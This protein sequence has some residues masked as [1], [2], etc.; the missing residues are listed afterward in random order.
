MRTEEIK[1]R[2]IDAHITQD[3][4][5]TDY[6]IPYDR[7][8][9]QYARFPHEAVYV[10]DCEKAEM[11]VLTD[12]FE[13]L[14]GVPHENLSI[15]P[16]YAHIN[17]HEK[18]KI[19]QG[20]YD[21]IRVVFSQNR[22]IP[23]HDT[24]TCVYKS[25][26]DRILLKNTAVLSQDSHEKMRYSIG[27]I[28]DVTDLVYYTGFRYSAKGTNS[29]AILASI[30]GIAECEPYL[31]KR[32]VEILILISKGLNSTQIG[33]VLFISKKTVDTHRKNMLKKLGAS[34]STEAYKKAIEAGLIT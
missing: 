32:E 15:D 27:K 10:I 20:Y 16:L 24:Y 8:R 13:K 26:N 23:E 14:T 17:T 19:M 31:S 12:N 1:N 4:G 28:I 6:S 2:I 18:D 33:E 9:S 34:N 7:L 11:E 29:A 30:N 5:S 25:V 22:W 21:L 3:Y